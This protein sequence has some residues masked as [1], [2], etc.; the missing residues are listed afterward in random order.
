[1]KLYLGG[2]QT[3]ETPRIIRSEIGRDFGFAFYTTDIREQAERWAWRRCRAA[4]R[5]GLLSAQ[6]VVSVFRFDDT[7]ARQKLSFCRNRGIPV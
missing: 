4:R 3:V 1:M 6:A 2:I 7:L 5:N